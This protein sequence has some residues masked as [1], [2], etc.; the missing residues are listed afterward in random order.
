M[1]I[2]QL[3]M[4]GLMAGASY[5]LLA[6]GFCIIFSTVRFIP[7]SHAIPY[8]TAAYSVY[9][10]VNYL[11]LPLWLASLSSVIIAGLIGCLPE[12]TVYR[13]LRKNRVSPSILMLTS[14]GLLIAFQSTVS[15]LFGDQTLVIQSRLDISIYKL[16]GAR[17]TSVQL[18][19]LIVT[20]I[21]FLAAWWF[22]RSTRIGKIQRAVASN[23]ELALILGVTTELIHIGVF[24][25]GSGIAGVAGI[26][27][28]HDTDAVP[29]MGFNSL[30]MGV[31]A[32]VVGGIGSIPGAVLGGLLVGL[33]Q[34]LA[35][36]KLPTLWQDGI[37]FLILIFF[38]FIR[39]Q[40]I[41]GNP[42]K[43]TS[44]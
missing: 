15:L 36:W 13:Q 27:A 32:T 17:L 1:L 19:V 7:F 30:L 38:L 29:T 4:N 9:L 25:V 10:L 41:L 28:A 6:L 8:T 5:A 16:L 23:P 33:V 20:V 3:I 14:L 34:H 43:K 35:V 31:V 40:G 42:L 44:I 37:V 26:L 18:T 24:A 12:I 2:V 11:G 21:L 39:P 22:S